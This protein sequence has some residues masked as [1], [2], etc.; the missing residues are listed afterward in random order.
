MD[1]YTEIPT[2]QMSSLIVT[3]STVVKYRL[4]NSV[5]IGNTIVGL[6]ITLDEKIRT[7]TIINISS[8]ILA[9][10]FAIAAPFIPRA[11]SPILPNINM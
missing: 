1:A 9:V 7:I 8:N 4:I 2:D 10:E 3:G 6:M 11:G 5:L